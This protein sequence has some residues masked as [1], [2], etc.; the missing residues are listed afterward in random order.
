MPFPRPFDDQSA[1]DRQDLKTYRRVEARITQLEREHSAASGERREQL[2]L[3]LEK[4]RKERD[5][6]KGTIGHLL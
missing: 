3:A 4:E 1:A 5:R 6:L 2:S